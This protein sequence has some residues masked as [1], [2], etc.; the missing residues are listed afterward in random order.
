MSQE[1]KTAYGGSKIVK[2]SGPWDIHKFVR[3]ISKWGF[4]ND[5]RVLGT[6]HPPF[7]IAPILQLQN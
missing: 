1:N 6:T 7:H 5:L 4:G 3:T 2:L